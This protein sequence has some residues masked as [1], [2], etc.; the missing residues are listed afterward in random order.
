MMILAGLVW[1]GWGQIQFS[2]VF[3]RQPGNALKRTSGRTSLTYRSVFDRIENAAQEKFV[4]I[5]EKSFS[6]VAFL[7]LSVVLCSGSRISLADEKEKQSGKPA[8]NRITIMQS[9][10]D[11]LIGDLE[12]MVKKLAKQSRTWRDYIEPNLEIFLDGVDTKKPIRVDVFFDQEMGEFYRLCFPY[13]NFKDFRNNIDA[14]G[15]ISTEKS[16][17]LYHLSDAYDGWMR[18]KYNYAIF[19]PED[20]K[21]FASPDIANPLDDLQPLLKAK[22]DT[23]VLINHDLAGMEQRRKSFAEINRNVLAGIKK[24]S[25]ESVAEYKLRKLLAENQLAEMERYYAE[26]KHLE[27]GWITDSEKNEGRGSLSLSALEGTELAGAL[28]QL[29]EAKSKFVV[30]P[31]SKDFVISGRLF[32]PIVKSQQDR[33]NSLFQ[34]FLPVQKKKIEEQKDLSADQKKAAQAALEKVIAMLKQGLDLGHVDG[35]VEMRRIDQ[36]DPHSVHELIGAMRAVKGREAEE[37]IKLLPKINDAFEVKMDIET[38]GDSHIHE[39]IVNRKV[40][41]MIDSLF[42]TPCRIHLGTSDDLLSIAVGGNAK[43]WLV[44]TLGQVNKAEAKA[45]PEFVRFKGHLKPFAVA[46]SKRKEKKDLPE[47]V[48]TT[49][50]KLI[51]AFDEQKFKQADDYIELIDKMV[52]GQVQGTMLVEPGLF[53]FIGLMIAEGARKNL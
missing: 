6:R 25:T 34:A 13:T 7:L 26:I 4:R 3:C 29:T 51:E 17:G 36:K 21:D 40:L 38:V 20:K 42:G 52:D 50:E 8:E 15:I 35:F 46:L 39:I 16:K 45:V 43:K 31:E 5:F 1:S 12:Y 23:A 10:A 37:I 53:R 27:A 19:V 18:T 22:F 11:G 2:R 33:Y 28:K 48:R 44:E 47:S 30:V 49:R 32:Y 9:S 24:K 41:P 14:S